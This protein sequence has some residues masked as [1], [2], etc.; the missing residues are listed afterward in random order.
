MHTWFI[1]LCRLDIDLS[2]IHPLC[3]SVCLPQAIE[4]ERPEKYRKLQEATRTA[5]ALVEQGNLHAYILIHMHTQTCMLPSSVP[6][7]TLPPVPPTLLVSIETLTHR[8]KQTERETSHLSFTLSLWHR[9][10]KCSFGFF[11]PNLKTKHSWTLYNLL[12]RAISVY[13]LFNVA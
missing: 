2:I 13:F 7:A 1:L 8:E 10:T 4:R 5:Q 6:M 9:N 11:F 12:T 3:L